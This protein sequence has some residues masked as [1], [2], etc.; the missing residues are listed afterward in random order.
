MNS[1]IPEKMDELILDLETKNLIDGLNESVRAGG[2]PDHPIND[3]ISKGEA[4][5]MFA[6]FKRRLLEKGYELEWNRD[7]YQLIKEY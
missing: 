7:E 4:T 6:E 2:D 1:N 5:A 3:V